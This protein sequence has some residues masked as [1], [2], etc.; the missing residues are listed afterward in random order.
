MV[1]VVA[2]VPGGDEARADSVAPPTDLIAWSTLSSPKVWVVKRSS[3][4]RFDA[5]CSRASS[6]ALKLCPRALLM[7]IAFT[8][9]FSSGKFGN[10]FISPWTRRVPALRLSAS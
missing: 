1:K 7:V 8:V 5:S 9:S 10:S 2:D 3:G 6:H 4:N